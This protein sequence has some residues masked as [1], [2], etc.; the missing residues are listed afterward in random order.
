MSV[1]GPRREVRMSQPPCPREERTAGQR[2]V[3]ELRGA[4]AARDDAAPYAAASRGWMLLGA[5][6]GQDPELF[7]P[8]GSHGP[9]RSQVEAAKAVCDRCAVCLECFAYAVRTAQEDGIWGGT[10]REERQAVT[11]TTARPAPALPGHRRSPALSASGQVHPLAALLKILIGE[12]PRHRPANA[13]RP[14]SVAPAAGPAA[15]LTGTRCAPSNDEKADT[16]RTG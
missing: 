11:K 8:A 3:R 1:P 16:G 12:S 9:A 15:M 14:S 6:Q 2:T 10:T 4:L 5:C 7:F 13:G